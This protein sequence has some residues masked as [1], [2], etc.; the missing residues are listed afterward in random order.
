MIRTT[1]IK[2]HVHIAKCINDTPSYLMLHYITVT[3]LSLSFRS[4]A[5]NKVKLQHC[6]CLYLDVLYFDRIHH[7]YACIQCNITHTY[8]M[9]IVN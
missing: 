6:L 3:N 9:Y 8:I 1:V 2:L 7:I 5:L 4:L